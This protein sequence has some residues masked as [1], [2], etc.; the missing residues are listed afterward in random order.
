MFPDNPGTVS[1]HHYGSMHR[2]AS[3]VAILGLATLVQPLA[4]HAAAPA[5]STAKTLPTAA[6]AALP[7]APTTL[8]APPRSLASPPTSLAAPPTSL[9][10]PPRVPHRLLGR[11]DALFGLAAGTAT[12]MMF[13]S[14]RA[15]TDEAIESD[16][17]AQRV[18]AR[19]AQ[20]LGNDGLVAPALLVTYGAARLTGHAQLAASTERVGVSIAAAAVTA[21]AIKEAVAGRTARPLLFPHGRSSRRGSHTSSSRSPATSPSRRATRRSPSRRRAP[22][23]ARRDPHGSGPSS[24]R[25]RPPS[26]GRAST[27][28]STGRA[29]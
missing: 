19:L 13:K 29:T 22:S 18:L 6:A 10:S 20:P 11:E 16:S 4:A 28:A 12:L 15:A 24:I 2:R 27:I 17:H 14:D 9:A 7:S 5:D 25:P 1:A 26:R 21:I 3:I 23:I 8:A